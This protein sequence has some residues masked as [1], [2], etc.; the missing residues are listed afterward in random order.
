[1]NRMS[2]FNLGEFRTSSET[3]TAYISG[4]TF[5]RKKVTYHVVDGLAILEGDIVL[6][7]VEQLKAQEAVA[8]PG[9]R[10]YQGL[11]PYEIDPNLPD[12]GRITQAI[13]HWQ[14]TTN[15][16]FKKRTLSNSPSYPNYVCFQPWSGG[17]SS[18]M[19][20]MHLGRN[21]IFIGSDCTRG[22]AIHEI[23][24]AV[25]LWHEQ[26]REDRDNFVTIHYENMDQANRDQFDQHI[27]DGDDI[28]EYDYCSIMHYPALAFSNNGQDTIEVLQPTRPCGTNIGQRDGLS[29]GDIAAY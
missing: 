24:H 29:D 10:W 11:V 26:A 16:R 5:D 15:I 9:N 28:G 17:C 27:T 25:G 1:M 2:R 4:F 20:G 8:I 7:T 23:G 3:G 12:Q 19:V 14:S 18:T 21:D 6:G 22:N 13:A